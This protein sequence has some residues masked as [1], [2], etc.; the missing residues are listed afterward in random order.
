VLG[1]DGNPWA[2]VASTTHDA[3]PTPPKPRRSGLHS[4]SRRAPNGMADG[5]GKTSPQLCVQEVRR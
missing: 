5:A 4:R 3:V 1:F 2:Q